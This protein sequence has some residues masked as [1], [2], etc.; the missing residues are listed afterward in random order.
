MSEQRQQGGPRPWSVTNHI[1][2]SVLPASCGRPRGPGPAAGQ[3]RIEEPLSGRVVGSTGHH[4]GGLER[5]RR[6]RRRRRT[7]I[8]RENWR[9]SQ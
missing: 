1:T 8:G 2:T 9:M 3:P 7:G 6:R 5:K 4:V